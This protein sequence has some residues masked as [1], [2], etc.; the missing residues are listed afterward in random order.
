MMNIG[1]LGGT[2]NPPHCAHL[3]IAEHVR[4]EAGLD[5][6]LFVPSYISPHKRSGEDT[7]AADRLAMTRKAIRGNRHF[8]C[9]EYEI[10]KR[11]VSYT[12][13]TL[14]Y[15]HGTY[16]HALLSLLIGMD[17]F[18]DL[19]RWKHT[20]KIV[21]LAEI[22]VMNRPG[23]ETGWPDGIPKEKVRFVTVPQL[24]ISSSAIR[25]RMDEGKSIT[26]LVPL[27][28]EQYILSHHLY[29]ST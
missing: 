15:L 16:P 18:L 25:R 29:K 22:I 21:E 13:E 4:I 14:E 17:N 5:K 1:I 27:N 28:V 19:A 10:A 11:S 26:Y 2:F 7:N 6:I 8:E 24:E 23:T 20:D 3:M 9:C 12:H